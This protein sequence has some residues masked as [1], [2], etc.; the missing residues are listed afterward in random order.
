[1]RWV[2]DKSGGILEEGLDVSS[3]IGGLE[4]LDELCKI[5]K[6]GGQN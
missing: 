3:K 6:R 2:D 4:N 1:M 5:E